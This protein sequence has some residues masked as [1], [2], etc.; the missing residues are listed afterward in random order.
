MEKN[1]LLLSSTTHPLIPQIYNEI[2]NHCNKVIF[3]IVQDQKKILGEILSNFFVLIKNLKSVI[4]LSE[5]FFRDYKIY[6]VRRHFLFYFNLLN[7]LILDKKYNFNIIDAHWIFPAGYLATIYSR[8]FPKKIIMTAHGY[9]ADQ[10]TFGN[11]NMSKIVLKSASQ[12]NIILTA[13]KRLYKNLKKYGITN[14]SLTNQFIDLPPLDFDISKI[15]KKLNLNQDSFI[16]TVGPRMSELF[17]TDDFVK[18]ILKIHEKISELY[19]V[20]LGDGDMRNY[21][22]MNLS[23]K[24]ILYRITGTISHSSV[25]DYLKSSDIV[26]SLG[27]ISHGIFPLEAWAYEK[28]V[29]GFGNVDELKIDNGV[30]GLLSETGNVENLS[31]NILKLYH[32]PSLKKEFGR[33]GRKKIDREYK[34]ENRIRDILE[35][36]KIE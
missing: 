4:L 31:K 9:D 21:I 12:A 32:E 29:I 22:E 5:I 2:K 14:V 6:G 17:G 28:P 33:N 15:R 10:R 26:C 36:Y 18:A 19:V 25:L 13:E 35:A 16:I 1:V 30:N 23:E 27:K 34:K 11:P 7:M 24:E 3:I 8:L 20:F